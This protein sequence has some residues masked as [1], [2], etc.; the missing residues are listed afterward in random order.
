[1]DARFIQDSLFREYARVI[2]LDENRLLFHVSF[3]KT[4]QEDNRYGCSPDENGY[5]PA[6]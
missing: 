3:Q 4:P 2:D 5:Y 1:M 6:A